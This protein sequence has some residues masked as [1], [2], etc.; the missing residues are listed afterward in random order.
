MR[1]V[2]IRRE[3]LQR[4][5]RA[6][7]DDYPEE[8]CGFLFSAADAA[9]A[10]AR[11]VASVE[12]APNVVGGERRRR[13]IISPE[14]LRSAEARAA[15]HSEVVSGFYHSHPDHPAVPSA[16][17]TE[18]AW[19]WY[20]YLIASVDARGA[21]AVGAF[22]LDSRERRFLP[23][24]LEGEDDRPRPGTEASALAPSR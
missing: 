3:L 13:F 16:F 9:N 6:A 20:T 24:A 17:D 18:H 22:E 4:V 2:R 8:A 5:E 7:L 11:T 10:T 21:H 1:T 19:P 12:R 14:E 23:V 15:T